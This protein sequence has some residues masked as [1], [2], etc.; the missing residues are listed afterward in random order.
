MSGLGSW[1]LSITAAALLVGVLEAMIPEG[2]VKA[3][4]ALGCGLLLFLVLVRPLLGGSYER[5][6]EELHSW[7][8]EAAEETERL[9]QVETSLEETIIAEDAAA[10][11]QA[12]AGEQGISC[13]VTVTC[14]QNGDGLTLPVAVEIEGVTQEAQREALR[15]LIQEAFALP[16]EQ[17]HFAET[18]EVR[19]DAGA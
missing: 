17:I 8:S 13:S 1:L 3:V 16:E 7:Q 2:S 18:E 11:I 19:Q 4:S 6:L 5:L 12:E 14:G 9:N 10:Y 15:T